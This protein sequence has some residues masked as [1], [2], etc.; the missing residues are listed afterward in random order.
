MWSFFSHIFEHDVFMPHGQC[1]MWYPGVLWLHVI[2]DVITA[3]AYFSIPLV[4]VY[5][6]RTQ[7]NVPHKWLYGMFGA[8]ICLCGTTH[9]ISIWVLWEPVYRLQG[10]VKALTA[11]VSLATAFMV[12]PLIPK[13][14]ELMKKIE[15]DKKIKRRKHG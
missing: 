11:G 6:L 2:S 13:H 8:F 9:L 12:I 10:F 5:I 3:L 15:K 7:K 4:I 1:F 14:I